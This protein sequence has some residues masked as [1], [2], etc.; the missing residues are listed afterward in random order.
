MMKNVRW[1]YLWDRNLFSVMHFFFSHLPFNLLKPPVQRPLAAPLWKPSGLKRTCSR[2]AGSPN[3]QILAVVRGDPAVPR[4][5]NTT[6]EKPCRAA[7][8]QSRCRW[9]VVPPQDWG[10]RRRT[11]VVEVKHPMAF[12]PD[13]CSFFTSH[14]LFAVTQSSATTPPSF[15]RRCSLVN[16]ML[17]A[18]S[19]HIWLE[20]VC[21]WGSP[22]GQSASF[23]F[24][25]E[26]QCCSRYLASA[27]GLQMSLGPNEVWPDNVSGGFSSRIRQI[28]THSFQPAALTAT[29]TQLHNPGQ[30]KPK[31]SR[32]NKEQGSKH[33]KQS[34]T[35][36]SIG[37]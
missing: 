34:N 4:W 12:L 29:F 30:R 14:L 2:S 21:R 35:Y 20:T 26:P 9:G 27:E 3:S 28:V 8:W 32:K 18:C 22:Q 33:N 24:V 1:K 36:D 6:T 25:S 11:G 23:A 7:C 19:P 37:E 31:L 17:S 15:S 13:C 10:M 16:W 5:W